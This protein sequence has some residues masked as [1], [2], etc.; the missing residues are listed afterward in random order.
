[1]NTSFMFGTGG[2]AAAMP[3][4]RSAFLSGLSRREASHG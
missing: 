1:M 2:G 3:L 4:Q